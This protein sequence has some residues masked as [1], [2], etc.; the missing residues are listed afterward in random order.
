MAK[1]DI[2]IEYPSLGTTY[3]D[4]AYGVYAYDEYPRHSVLAGQQRRKFLDS[5]ETL[6]EAQAKYPHAE[7]CGCG[8]QEPYLGHLPDGPDDGYFDEPEQPWY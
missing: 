3:A 8:F 5:F 4:N 7:L 1:Q 2:R 6:E